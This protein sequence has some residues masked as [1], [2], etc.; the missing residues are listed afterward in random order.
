MHLNL[1]KE[2]LLVNITKY[3]FNQN[4]GFLLNFYKIVT[5]MA[6]FLAS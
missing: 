3:E 6:A 4:L 1:K 5:F 2:L